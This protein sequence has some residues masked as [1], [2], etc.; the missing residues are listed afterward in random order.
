MK[1]LYIADYSN[2]VYKF[3]Y[4]FDLGVRLGDGRYINTSV[5]Y[6]FKNAI[7]S[8]RFD[9][10]I[11]AL[12]GC[13]LRSLEIL[14]QYK[15]QREHSTSD[16]IYVP[17]REVISYLTQLGDRLGKRVRVVASYG[18]E[19]DQVISSL[20]YLALGKVDP[21]SV[22]FMDKLVL[23]SLSEDPYIGSCVEEDVPLEL[24]SDYDTVILGTTDSDM[25]Q[26]REI[27]GVYMDS[28]W[29]GK[30]INF[31]ESTPKAVHGMPPCT[32]AVYKAFLGDASDN[33][34]AI[35][36]RSLGSKVRKIILE[37]LNSE[38]KFINFCNSVKLGLPLSNSLELLKSWV[39]KGSGVKDL[40]RNYSVVKLRFESTPRLLKF[41]SYTIEET[42]EKYSI[43]GL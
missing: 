8:N 3:K 40:R 9:D 43:K 17:K 36:S 41:P 28:S 6:G 2:W 39:L 12:D 13:P 33:V 30:S 19:A 7:K 29:N 4:V 31:S 1:T 5:L 21:G 37:E 14:P 24:E 42:L 18:Q 34:P 10:I 20:V 38:S 16:K 25:H 23:H 15:Q 32:I 26:L 22:R 35:V 27:S 11:I